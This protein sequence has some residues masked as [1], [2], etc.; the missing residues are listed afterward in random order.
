MH[1]AH[2]L[3][4]AEAPPAAR[5]Q[6]LGGD[7]AAAVWDTADGANTDRIVPTIDGEPA[8]RPYVTLSVR[9]RWGGHRHIVIFRWRQGSQLR[10]V[11]G[12]GNVVAEARLDEEPR[13]GPLDPAA[14]LDDLGPSARMRVVRLVLN[15]CRTAFQLSRNRPFALG[16]RRLAE[17]LSP[18]MAV[19]TAQL[20]LSDRLWLVSGSLPAGLG[21]VTAIYRI[22]D[23][24]V[25]ASAFLPLISPAPR[26]DAAPFHL[27]I[28]RLPGDDLAAPVLV[29]I[30]EKGIACRRV[31]GLTAAPPSLL[32][33]LERKTALPPALREYI[34]GSIAG[35]AA[36][37]P[38]A[39]ALVQEMQ[40]CLPLTPRKVTT[41]DRIA[42]DFELAISDG[43]GL[44]VGGWMH[45]PHE[46]VAEVAAISPL[47]ESRVLSAPWHRFPRDDIAKKAR[48]PTGSVSGFVTYLPDAPAQVPLLQ[49]RFELRLKSGAVIPLISPAQPLDPAAARAAVLGSIPAFR[50]TDAALE[51][52][53]APAAAAL[54]ARHLGR[55]R[56]AEAIRFGTQPG[57]PEATV[58]IPLYRTL[59]FLRF[60][61]AAFATDPF[62]RGTEL[63][64]VLD[65][66]EQRGEVEH[67]LRGLHGLYDLPMTLVVM[68]ANYGYAAANNAGAAIA[69]GRYLALVNSD[70]IPMAPGWIQTLT[71]RIAAED[72]LGAVGP[73][74]LFEDDSLQHAGMYF[75]RDGQ[76]RWLNQHYYKGMPRDFTPAI[77]E[78]SVPA[79]TGAC[80][81]TRRDVFERVGGFTEDYIIGDY[82]DSDLCLKI[83]GEGFDI[84][85]VPEAELYHL[86]RCSIQRH[87]EYMRGVASRYNAWLHAGRWHAEMERLMTTFEG[88]RG[89]EPWTTATR[90]RRGR[91]V[92]RVAAAPLSGTA[93]E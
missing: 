46:L 71:G 69:R 6:R 83:R 63:I 76:G 10:I 16:C 80:L 42:A 41:F 78:R 43:S 52:C 19:A 30:G 58:L 47:G 8:R 18:R 15:F 64:Y 27:A 60:Q 37:D 54:H 49:H 32:S 9:A 3:V 68:P 61:I 13:P 14:L 50:M 79:V 24:E 72:G 73:K 25:H 23:G 62:F 87:A 51:T 84:R 77:V 74:L 38:R 85:Y 90:P 70:V 86:E 29:L 93:A 67:L 22:G 40:V 1:S 89:M 31:E 88:D 21:K 53:I 91:R 57:A 11:D 82:E 4:T 66:P 33:W 56:E 44:F 26:G 17:A 2:L 81:V 12:A 39:A 92:P 36:A 35:T 75:G 28:E 65:S 5:L 34:A 55:R 20:A 7:A 45:D 48:R 59:D